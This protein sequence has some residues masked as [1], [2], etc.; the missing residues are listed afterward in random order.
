MRQRTSYTPAKITSVYDVASMGV[1]GLWGMCLSVRAPEASDST[2]SLAAAGPSGLRF[3]A[4][5]CSARKAATAAVHPRILRGLMSCELV[6]GEQ[7]V[8][9]VTT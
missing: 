7:N 5:R 3:A 9:F 1:T 2:M 8:L 4:H 6:D